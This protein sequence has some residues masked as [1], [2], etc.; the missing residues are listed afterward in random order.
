MK[1]KEEII[2]EVIKLLKDDVRIYQIKKKLS[3]LGV[4]ENEMNIIIDEAKKIYR[5]QLYKRNKI[6][7][8]SLLLLS[9][10]MFYFF[11]PVNWSN[12]FPYFI[13]IVGAVLAGLFL[14]LLIKNWKLRDGS[15]NIFSTYSI[16]IAII[17]G[18]IWLV[19][20]YMHFRTQQENELIKHG[21]LTTGIIISGE[22]TTSRSIRRRTSHYEVKV[23]FRTK[24]GKGYIVDK[25]IQW[26]EFN[27]LRKGQ[28][29]D[30]IYSKNNPTIID[31]LIDH[32]KITKYT[33][34]EERSIV[35]E[36]L[37][38]FLDANKKNLKPELDKIQLGWFYN[39]K[40]SLWINEANNT[41]IKFTNKENIQFI[42]TGTNSL[43]NSENSKA[44]GL[45]TIILNEKFGMYESEKYKITTMIDTN[46][47]ETLSIISIEKK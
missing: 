42:T 32:E 15:K 5:I 3:N 16:P 4:E 28:K 24:E 13:S 45:K 41:A 2:T 35:L 30:I 34:S 8:F 38:N 10:V 25:N 36:D 9:L 43:I 23:K 7:S 29:I 17:F 27:K 33:G 12:K 47:Q 21:Q 31:L 26:S 1:T 18:T 22:E 11:I 6:I 14:S 39:V 46:G 44:L 20:L 40:D 19:A 37:L